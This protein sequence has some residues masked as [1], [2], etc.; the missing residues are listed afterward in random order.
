M[1]TDP[2]GQPYRHN[3]EQHEAHKEALADFVSVADILPFWRYAV[4]PTSGQSPAIP[5]YRL[6][7]A[8]ASL[9]KRS[10]KFRGRGDTLPPTALPTARNRAGISPK[11]SDQLGY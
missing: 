5:F 3:A 8:V 6:A 1:S 10:A 7:A 4:G 9:M 11:L 2:D